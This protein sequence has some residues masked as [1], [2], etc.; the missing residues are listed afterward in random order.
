MAYYNGRPTA[1]G[2]TYQIGIAA[3][4]GSGDTRLVRALV[5]PLL[6]EGAA[7]A[8]DDDHVKDPF[9]LYDAGTWKM[10]YSGHDGSKYQIGYATSTD[11]YHWLK[12]A[13]NPALAV[14]GAGTFDASGCIFPVVYKDADA[15]A[16]KRYRMLYSGK[17]A[18]GKY[19]IGYAYSAD[20][21]SWT[22]GAANPVLALGGGGSWDDNALIAGSLVKS[23]GTYYVFY[24]G[25]HITTTP[26]DD[27]VGLATFTDF[28]GTYTKF[29]SNPV[30]SHRTGDQALA[31]NLSAGGT[32]VQVAS[33]AGF[34]VGEVVYLS[35][36]TNA[37]EVKVAAIPDGTHVTIAD[38]ANVSYTTAN[39]ARITTTLLALTPRTVVLENGVWR[40]WLSAYQAGVGNSSMEGTYYATSTAPDT[41]WAFS[42]DSNSPP[43]P[44]GNA[45]ALGKWDSRSTE[46]PA[47]LLD[48]ATYQRKVIP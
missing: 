35:D 5:A 38:V 46:N 21:V 37:Q 10:W 19:Q 36:G 26:V 7:G 40:M 20:G 47:F 24:G 15:A 2:G 41:G 18:S 16:N 8:W 34:A 6:G 9:V 13:N 45:G 14:G 33:S 44:L 23:G 4:G 29:A 39:S 1:A 22:K 3:T 17:N 27:S 43:L 25:R 28:E 32:S 11:G 48:A 12:G 30:L 31:A 42:H